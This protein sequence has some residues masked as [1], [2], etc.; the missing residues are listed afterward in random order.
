MPVLSAKTP[1]KSNAQAPALPAPAL[2]FSNI[3]TVVAAPD[4]LQ[5]GI[6]IERQA[7]EIT[8]PFRVRSTAAPVASQITAQLPQMLTKAEKQT[9]ELRLDPPELGRVTIHLTTND[10]Q[11]TA[12]VIAEARRHGRPDAPPRRAAH[13]HFGPRR[14][15][16][17]QPFVSTGARAK[18]KS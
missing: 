18:W 15:F 4:E 16:T 10:Q 12:T 6:K 5:F 7:T 9:V 17:S 2:G 14:F 1:P 11:V 13:C 3:E 8:H